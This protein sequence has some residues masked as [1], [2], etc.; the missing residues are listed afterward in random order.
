M[1]GAARTGPERTELVR[2]NAGYAWRS[3]RQRQRSRWPF[4][5]GL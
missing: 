1:Q 2:E 5:D 4:M 3:N